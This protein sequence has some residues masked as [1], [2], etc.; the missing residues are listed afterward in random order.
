METVIKWGG[1]IKPPAITEQAVFMI[2]L[3]YLRHPAYFR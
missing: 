1:D 3:R 2:I